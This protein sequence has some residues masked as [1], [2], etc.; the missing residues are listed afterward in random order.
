MT[1]ATHLGRELHETGTMDHDIN[2]KKAEFIN[3]RT[4]LRETFAFANPVEVLRAVKVFAGDLYGSNLWQ[5]GSDMA[6]QVY[7]AWN[8]TIKLA[9]QVPRGTHTYFVDRVLSCGIS[10]V[11]TDIL[12]KYVKFF[13]S[14]RESPSMEVSV[15]S[16]IVA[17]DVRTTTGNNLH[18]I[19]DMTGLDPWSCLG[20]QV[21]KVLGEKL[22]EVP[23]QDSWRLLYLEKLLDQR[24]EMYYRVEDTTQL[25][26]LIDSI[27]LN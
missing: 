26:E 20:N 25:T 23:Q 15:L 8:T 18:L 9:W 24:G 14:L 17:R 27:C 12:A 3:K 5:L 1:S 4:E 7:H 2:V 10:H 21:K 22:A 6:G 13:R 11:K 16:H 19:R